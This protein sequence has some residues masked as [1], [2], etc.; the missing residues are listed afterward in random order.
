MT[1]EAELL[2]ASMADLVEVIG[3]PAVLKLMD[4]F[5]GT[6]FWVP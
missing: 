2:P 4:A 3:L 5:G 1:T 6:E